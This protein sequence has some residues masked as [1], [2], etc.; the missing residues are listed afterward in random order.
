MQV[1]TH[2]F[3]VLILDFQGKKHLSSPHLL[4]SHK[5]FLPLL[6]GWIMPMSWFWMFICQFPSLWYPLIQTQTLHKVYT[7]HRRSTSMRYISYPS[8]RWTRTPRPPHL[9]TSHKAFL[10][11]LAGW[12]M[13]MSWFWIFI[14]QFPSLWYPFIQTQTLH[15]V[16]TSHRRSTSM[17]YISYPSWRWKFLRFLV[18]Y[19]F[20]GL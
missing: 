2:I 15:K 1:D 13:P 6:A 7:S 19:T 8:G 20:K 9:L 3:G 4:T 10:P 12:I 5:A 18:F 16:Y 14:C 11:R 17:R